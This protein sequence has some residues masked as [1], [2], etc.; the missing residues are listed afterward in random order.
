M[1]R[2]AIR[3]DVKRNRLLVSSVLG[4]GSDVLEVNGVEG[5]HDDLQ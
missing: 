3:M 2:I 4:A 5:G 1:K